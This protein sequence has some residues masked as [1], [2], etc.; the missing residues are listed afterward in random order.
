MA[1]FVVQLGVLTGMF[2][3]V[4]ALERVPA[5]QHTPSR[6][7][8]PWFETDV[9]WYLVAALAAGVSVFV[10]RPILVRLAI[11]GLSGWIGALSGW[12]A[13]PIAVVVFDGV[14]FAVHR[15]L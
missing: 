14:F 11:P 10:L 7:H 3:V 6:F 2:L 13:L 4:A 12:A 5:L 8:R 9:L 15:R 1:G